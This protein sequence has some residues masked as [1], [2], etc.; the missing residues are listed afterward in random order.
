MPSQISSLLEQI[1]QIS[2]PLRIILF[3]SAARGQMGSESDIDL[4][5]VM[6]TPIKEMGQVQEIR[7]FLNPL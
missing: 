2:R 3:G 6:D 1:I 5:V 7:R 4:L